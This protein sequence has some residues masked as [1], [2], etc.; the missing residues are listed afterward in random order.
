MIYKRISMLL[1]S[2]ILILCMIPTYAFADDS[3]AE[4][5][6]I[7]ITL[8]KPENVK[9]K[10]LGQSKIKLTWSKVEGAE[11]YKIYRYN[12]SKG[13]YVLIKTTEGTS[14]VNKNLRANRT[15]T[16]KV[17]AYNSENIG[18][19]SDKAKAKT[20]P[21]TIRVKA[22]AY[23]GGG[24]TASGL[25]AR[26]GVI[27]VDPRLIKLG[28]KVYVPGYGNAI[29]ADTGSAIK[30]RIIDCYMNTLKQCCNWGARYVTI[31]VYD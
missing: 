10:A 6:N 13:K 19:K 22:V 5:N 28:T 3:M 11:G 7:T 27:A 29:A 9:A 31:T 12:K 25:K 20:K 1:L 23:T 16:Y 8:E 4:D 30:G 24:Y 18:P 14:F 26:P 21:R 2:A 15:K 17:A